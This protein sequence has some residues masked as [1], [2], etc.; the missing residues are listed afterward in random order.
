MREN[1]LHWEP[2]IGEGTGDGTE[3]EC[4]GTNDG[5]SDDGGGS[6]IVL[7]EDF[8]NIVDWDNITTSTFDDEHYEYFL[9][10]TKKLK[11]EEFV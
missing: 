8:S 9:I 1:G 7:L 6:S 5:G 10:Q 11:Y 2:R 3:E 4:S